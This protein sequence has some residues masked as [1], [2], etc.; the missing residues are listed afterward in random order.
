M[1]DLS[2]VQHMANA[3]CVFVSGALAYVSVEENKETMKAD[4]TLS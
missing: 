3:M 4:L 1:P 2:A